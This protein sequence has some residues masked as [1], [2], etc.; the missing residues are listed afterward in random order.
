VIAGSA[1]TAAGFAL[2]ASKLA[3]ADLGTQ[4][5]WLVVAG[6]GMGLVLSPASTDALDQAPRGS[7]GEVTGITQTVRYLASSVG[8]AVLGTVF[9]DRLADRHP[10]ADATEA[11]FHAMAGVMAVCFLVAIAGVRNARHA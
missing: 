1:I 7:F 9:I 3:D 2:W 6:L 10:V 5:P 11:V 4:W 8:L